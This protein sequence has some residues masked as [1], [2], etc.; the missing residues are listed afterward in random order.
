MKYID[1]EKLKAEIERQMKF[2]D[3]KEMKAWDDSEQG[4][5]DA[6]WYQGHRKMC[7]K[8]LTFLDTLEEQPVGEELEKE[9]EKTWLEY[10]YYNEDYDKVAEMR[11]N[12]FENVARHFYEFGKQAMKQQM[13]KDAIERVVKEDLGG[14]PYIDATIEL[15]DCDKDIPTAKKGDR[16]RI[17][18]VKED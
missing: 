18:I 1:A 6:L 9:I 4:D 11:W 14:Y 12:E 7:A 16:V 10:E 15:Y 5:E 2:Y 13:L 3:E 17:I 8:L